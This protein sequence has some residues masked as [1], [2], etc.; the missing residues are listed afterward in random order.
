MKKNNFKKVDLDQFESLNNEELKT[1]KGGSYPPATGEID[2]DDILFPDD[3]RSLYTFSS[4]TSTLFT[5]VR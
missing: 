3:F 5:R 1:I 4:S 2:L